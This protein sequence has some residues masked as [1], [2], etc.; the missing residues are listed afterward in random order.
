MFIKLK[1]YMEKQEALN[2]LKSIEQETKELRKIIEDADK[3]KTIQERVIDLY[4]ACKETNRDYSNFIK[5]IQELS[6]DTQAYECLKV[7]CEALNEGTKIT[8]KGYS[9]W[10]D[11]TKKVGSSFPYSVSTCAAG[12]TV[13]SRLKLKSSNLAI[14]CGKQFEQLWYEYIV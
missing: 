7:I 5:S 12:S 13:S 3:P 11:L 4:S 2:R 8:T 1:K 10:F 9:P 6:K 14:Y